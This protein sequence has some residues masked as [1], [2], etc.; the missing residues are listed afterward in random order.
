M[1]FE[2]PWFLLLLII[3]AAYFITRH[4]LRSK[5]LSIPRPVIYYSSSDLI[6]RR[7]S[8]RASW[9]GF[10]SDLLVLAAM[11]LFIIAL[12]R[13]L[14]GRA[15]TNDRFFGIDIILAIDV[16]GS[17]LIVDRIPSDLPYRDFGGRR[18]YFDESRRL[19]EQNRLNSAKRVIE[20]YVEKQL[21]NRI[22]LVLFA[23]YSH[24]R[25]PL[26][27]DKSMLTRIIREIGFNPANDGTAIGMGLAT[28]VNRLRNSTAKSRVIILLTDGINNTGMIAPLSAADIAR[29]MGIK[30][31]TI[32]LGNPGGFLQPTSLEQNKYT[33]E[34]GQGIDEPILQKIAETTGGRFY[35]AYDPESLKK[36]YDDIDTL[37]K[38][39][40]QVKRRLLFHEN[41]L[42]FLAA[43]FILFLAW[44]IFQA[45]FLKIP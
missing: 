2:N 21:F 11:V 33:F 9:H 6:S 3:P 17:M 10:I 45:V 18:F 22:G 12:A 34:K 35:R 44:I 26:T 39:Q 29:Q 15:V 37:E 7:H 19:M 38:T 40:I 42:P 31:Y 13:P 1:W 43:G 28:A 36:I 4:I 20:G 32:G 27:L 25:C 5:W 41:F 30:V 23:G 16:S 14:G 8:G 24:T